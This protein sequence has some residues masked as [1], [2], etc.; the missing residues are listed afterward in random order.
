MRRESKKAG[1]EIAPLFL[2]PL[3]PTQ[4]NYLLYAYVLMNNH[5][6]L[7]IETRETPLSKSLQG[8]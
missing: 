8:E 5:M 1:R 6:H 7:L 3:K 4:C 2:C